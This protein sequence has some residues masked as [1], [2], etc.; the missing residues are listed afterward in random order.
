MKDYRIPK[1]VFFGQLAT[2]KRLAGGPL[3]RYKDSLKVNLKRCSLDPKFL[4]LDAQNRSGW[5]STCRAAVAEFEAAR[6]EALQDKRARRK[7]AVHTGAWACSACPRNLFVSHRTLCL[8]EDPSEMKQ[9]VGSTVQSMCVCGHIAFNIFS[10]LITTGIAKQYGF[11][12]K[13][14]SF[15]LSPQPT[16]TQL[17]M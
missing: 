3:Q 5:R 15:N 12:G 6:V 4:C 13:G 16:N 9:S 10:A 17:K 2:G 1:Q 8:Y 14:C 11:G 7:Q